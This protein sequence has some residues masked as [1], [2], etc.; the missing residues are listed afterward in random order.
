MGNVRHKACILKPHSDEILNPAKARILAT[1]V[2]IVDAAYLI[3]LGIRTIN[4]GV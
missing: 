4:D 2:H 3:Q 1:R